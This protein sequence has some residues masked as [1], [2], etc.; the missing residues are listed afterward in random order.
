MRL[1]IIIGHTKLKKGAKG[2]YPIAEY[3]YDFNFKLAMEFFRQAKS[4]DMDCQLFDKSNS[5]N[6]E[7]YKKVDDFLALDLGVSIELHFNASDGKAYGTETLYVTPQSLEVASL[8]QESMCL[9]L[10]RRSK[11]NRGYKKLADGDRGF[12]NLAHLKAPAILIEPAFC[13]N[14]D[15]ARLFYDYKEK[16]VHN[17]IYCVEKY[18]QK[19]LDSPNKKEN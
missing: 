4:I 2:V 14:K 10:S 18:L 19:E 11:G 7:I 16:L 6:G 3:E 12:H 5:L 1:A 13:D 15:D 17:I 9:T 8:V